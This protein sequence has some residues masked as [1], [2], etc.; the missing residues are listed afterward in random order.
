MDD[1]ETKSN[2]LLNGIKARGSL[3][4]FE[5]NSYKTL[6]CSNTKDQIDTITR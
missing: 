3:D 5:G 2:N 4:L 6:K 1:I